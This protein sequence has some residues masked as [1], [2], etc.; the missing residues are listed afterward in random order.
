MEVFP[1]AIQSLKTKGY[2]LHVCGGVSSGYLVPFYVDEFS[3][4]MWR[5]FYKRYRTLYEAKIFSTY[6][7]VFLSRKRRRISRRDFL[8]VCGGVSYCLLCKVCFKKFSPRMWRCFFIQE[9]PPLERVIFSTYVEVFLDSCNA[10]LRCADFLHV[11]GGVS[12]LEKMLRTF[13]AFS[14]RM[15]RCFLIRSTC[16]ILKCIFS[17]YVEVFLKQNGN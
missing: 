15:W 4:R 8:H 9:D 16:L 11:C 1:I 14:P 13:M 2:F 3:P 12:R 10:R 6:V 17:T 5:C 7:E